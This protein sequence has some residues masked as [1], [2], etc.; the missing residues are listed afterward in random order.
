MR[1]TARKVP[2]GDSS[3]STQKKNAVKILSPSDR[4]DTVMTDDE[5][6]EMAVGDS[7]SPKKK[8]KKKERKRP[9][10]DKKKS[11]VSR[12]IERSGKSMRYM[13]EV[14]KRSLN[15]SNQSSGSFSG[16]NGTYAISLP[17]GVTKDVRG[18]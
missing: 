3:S 10:Y 18:R 5:R 2:T 15:R 7:I 6:F 9:D 12:S 13:A 14:I 17:S 4:S 1:V 11:K 8:V 16:G